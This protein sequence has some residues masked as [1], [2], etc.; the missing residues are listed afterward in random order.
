[1]NAWKTIMARFADETF[2]IQEKA[3]ILIILTLCITVTVPLV[4]VNDLVSGDMLSVIGESAIML[5]MIVAF[6]MLVR[7]SYRGAASL[8]VVMVFV[9]LAF[10]SW[11]AKDLTVP[12]FAT[13]GFYMIA[14]VIVSALI[15]YAALQTL[16][17]GSGGAAVLVAAFLLRILPANPGTQA[18]DMLS[19]LL[20]TLVIYVLLSLVAT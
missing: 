7:G 2:E 3:K 8:V 18:S 9:A 13:K 15:G 4:M 19:A 14:P 11:I 16:I 5:A 6:L 1:M 10:L 12:A 17:V 20:S